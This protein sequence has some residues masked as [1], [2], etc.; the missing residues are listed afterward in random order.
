MRNNVKISNWRKHGK[1]RSRRFIFS[2]PSG[3]RYDTHGVGFNVTEMDMNSDGTWLHNALSVHLNS[4][5]DFEF[6][7]EISNYN[8]VLRVNGDVV[9]LNLTDN[10]KIYMS[11]EQFDKLQA[12]VKWHDPRQVD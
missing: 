7:P 11:P 4:R 2:A 10:V 3:N 1:S 9:S 12:V 8:S 6:D 5:D